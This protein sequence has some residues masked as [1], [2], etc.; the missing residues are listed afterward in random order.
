M[1]PQ[2]HGYTVVAFHPGDYSGI[3]FFSNDGGG[4][5]TVLS[6]NPDIVP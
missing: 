5:G 4:K 2:W 3:V 6:N 1:D